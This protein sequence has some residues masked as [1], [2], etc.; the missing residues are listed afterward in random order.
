MFAAKIVIVKIVSINNAA[1]FLFCST[2]VCNEKYGLG[3]GESE[4]SDTIWCEKL[5]VLHQTSLVV[6]GKFISNPVQH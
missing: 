3:T 4:Q 5:K 1:F 6:Y 2:N